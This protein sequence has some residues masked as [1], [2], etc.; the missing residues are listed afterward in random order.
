MSEATEYVLVAEKD[1]TRAAEIARSVAN[2]KSETVD[3][4]LIANEWKSSNVEKSHY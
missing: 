2:S 1:K 3:P 4:R